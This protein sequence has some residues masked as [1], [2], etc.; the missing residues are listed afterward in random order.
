MQQSFSD[1]KGFV[2][3]LQILHIA[4]VVG[5]TLVLLILSNRQFW[6]KKHTFGEV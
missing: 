2:R 1:F 5:A 4:M 6:L 3:S